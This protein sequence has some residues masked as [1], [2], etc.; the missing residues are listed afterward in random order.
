M[1]EPDPNTSHSVGVA[2]EP[3]VTGCL[4]CGSR[5]S[6][7]ARNLA[8]R[9]RGRSGQRFEGLPEQLEQRCASGAARLL[10]RC[11]HLAAWLEK[12]VLPDVHQAGYGQVAAV[13]QS[14]N[15]NDAVVTQT[16]SANVATI[17]Q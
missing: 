2:S 5:R 14:G 15:Y 10:Q 9:C 8:K 3:D 1:R 4:C 11:H 12:D 6:L 17:T 16:G 13:G 7:T